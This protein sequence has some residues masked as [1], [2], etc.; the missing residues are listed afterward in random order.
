V[1]SKY[2]TVKLDI[3]LAS[4]PDNQNKMISNQTVKIIWP[5]FVLCMLGGELLY[6][7]EEGVFFLLTDTHFVFLI[8]NRS[9][10]FLSVK[11]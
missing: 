6:V 7:P 11:K 5:I 9:S 4:S 8:I 3:D 2:R 10:N 1:Y